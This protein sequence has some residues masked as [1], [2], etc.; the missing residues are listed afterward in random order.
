MRPPSPGGLCVSV[1]ASLRFVRVAY[2]R[3]ICEQCRFWVIF[4]R[5]GQQ[6][7]SISHWA[8][9]T[10]TTMPFP[11]TLKLAVKR[12]A[13]FMCCLCRSL[14]VEVHHIVAE[15]EDGPN[16][17]D[18]AAPLCP[19]CHEIYGA[20]AQK[21][22]FIREARELWYEI[23]ERRYVS[24]PDR[25]DELGSI[26]SATA[27][28]ADLEQAVQHLTDAILASQR[29]R[30]RGDAEKPPLDQPWNETGLRAYL[31]WLFPD[32]THCGPEAVEKLFADLVMIGYRSLEELHRVVGVTRDGFRDFATERRDEAGMVDQF[33]DSYPMRLFLALF[34]EAYCKVH[35]PG[36]YAKRDL[37]SWRRAEPPRASP[38][39]IARYQAQKPRGT[40]EHVPAEP[41]VC[42]G[43]GIG[44]Q[45]RPLITLTL[46]AQGDWPMTTEQFCPPCARKRGHKAQ[47]PQ[48]MTEDV[49][50]ADQNPTLKEH[51]SRVLKHPILPAL[52]E[53]SDLRAL[54]L[55]SVGATLGGTSV[56]L[57]ISD[58]EGRTRET[59]IALETLDRGGIFSETALLD[60]FAAAVRAALTN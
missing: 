2:T 60:H 38:A 47:I 19:S 5:N 42:D 48:G 23:C 39:S 16:T 9:G 6:M 1:F 52:R 27:T 45:F 21:R 18:N 11:E 12:R 4:K 57:I 3:R 49:V 55:A 17:E 58:P 44:V 35:Y 24:D 37:N 50:Y 14:G 25:I 36:V 29:T 31:R 28:K 51:L 22:K 10:G 8:A 56:S 20:N 54:G 59:E 26:L 43:C 15:A 34:D 41:Q 13:H 32:V 46:P 30:Q 33:T 7:A 40:N 53:R